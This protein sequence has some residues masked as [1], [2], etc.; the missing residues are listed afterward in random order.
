MGIGHSISELRKQLADAI[1]QQRAGDVLAAA[2]QNRGT[3]QRVEQ[4]GGK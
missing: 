4:R 1:K 2:E 3:Q